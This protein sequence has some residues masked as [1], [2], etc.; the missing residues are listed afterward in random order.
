MPCVMI[1][2]YII[3]GLLLDV[4]IVSPCERCLTTPLLIFSPVFDTS[5]KV[6]P[7][8]LIACI[9]PPGELNLPTVLS[10]SRLLKLKLIVGG[11]ALIGMLCVHII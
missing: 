6:P 4:L 3:L 1:C 2:G 5:C 8:L 10:V 11:V 9:D 7:S